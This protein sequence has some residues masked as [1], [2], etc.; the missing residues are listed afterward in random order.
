VQQSGKYGEVSATFVD[1][2]TAMTA[3]TYG[4]A[5]GTCES[6]PARKSLWKRFVTALIESRMRKAEE[7][8][9]RYRHLLPQ[10]LEWAAH[11]LGPR[12]ED[13]LPFIR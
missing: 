12:S 9:R 4:T 8:I 1:R 7:E 6:K 10:E 2:E 3:I 5:I 11:K 13:Q